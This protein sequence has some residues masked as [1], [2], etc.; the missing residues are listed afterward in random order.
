LRS[1][2]GNHGFTLAEA[3]VSMTILAV[4]I[5]G[6]L[7]AFSLASRSGSEAMRLAEAARLAEWQLQLVLCSDGSDFAPEGA[8]G[9]YKW[10]AKV[11]DLREGLQLASVAVKWSDR[12]G[13]RTF[14]LSEVFLPRWREG[15]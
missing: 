1:G 15:D 8:S 4:G 12:G 14:E 11:T 13:A 3:L 7:A 2:I 9:P 6:V 5:V 10:E